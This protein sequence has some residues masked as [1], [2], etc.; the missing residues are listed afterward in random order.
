MAELV[1]GRF[2][3]YGGLGMNVNGFDSGV[4]L[5]RMP[6]YAIDGFCVTKLRLLPLHAHGGRVFDSLR[7]PAFEF[8]PAGRH[9]SLQD[10]QIS[11]DQRACHTLTA[12]TIH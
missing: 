3:A 7:L 11:P 9:N 12:V 2:T 4:A 1:R 8:R 10:G 6:G 5:F